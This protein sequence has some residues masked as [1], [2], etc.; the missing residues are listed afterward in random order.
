MFFFISFE[1]LVIDFMCLIFLKIKFGIL[2]GK[3]TKSIRNEE[4]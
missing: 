1:D 4:Q 2:P 3:K